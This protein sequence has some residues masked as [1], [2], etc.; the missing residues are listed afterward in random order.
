[1]PAWCGS[2]KYPLVCHGSKVK[3]AT[4]TSHYDRLSTRGPVNI[5]RLDGRILICPMVFGFL[6][7]SIDQSCHAK[8]A[9]AC[10][11]QLL[12]AGADIEL[13]I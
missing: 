10:L 13:E 5:Y 9:Y 2:T 4:C 1:M 11:A 3:Y 12:F 6:Q 8:F 7:S